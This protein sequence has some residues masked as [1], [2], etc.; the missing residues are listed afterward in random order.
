MTADE[1]RAAA[2]K[3]PAFVAGFDAAMALEY[4]PAGTPDPANPHLDGT[5]D[6]RAWA[7]GAEQAMAELCSPD[8]WRDGGCG[9]TGIHRAMPESEPA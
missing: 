1:K 2:M 5:A 8:S 3:C 9:A 4:A 6:R 7:L